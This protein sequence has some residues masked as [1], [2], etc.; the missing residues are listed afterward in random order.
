MSHYI[1]KV[2]PVSRLQSEG[3]LFCN[4][5]TST[6]WLRFSQPRRTLLTFKLSCFVQHMCEM[7]MYMRHKDHFASFQL[8]FTAFVHARSRSVFLWN[9]LHMSTPSLFPSYQV[10]KIEIKLSCDA[11][12]SFFAPFVCPFCKA[13]ILSRAHLCHLNTPLPFPIWRRD[14]QLRVDLHRSLQFL[15]S[16]FKSMKKHHDHKHMKSRA[17]SS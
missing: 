7:K 1:G 6:K 17:F 11:G 2:F 15:P 14:R 8:K 16:Y 13:I 4:L 5:I 9:L 3:G 10:H 12:S